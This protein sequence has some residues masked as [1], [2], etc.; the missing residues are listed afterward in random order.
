MEGASSSPVN[1]SATNAA[2]INAY[3]VVLKYVSIV[4]NCGLKK[5]SSADLKFQI[6]NPQS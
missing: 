6:R 1:T 3:E 5:L 4:T 2:A